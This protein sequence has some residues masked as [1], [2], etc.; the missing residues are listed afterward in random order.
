MT[1][2]T[3]TVLL[4]LTKKI[5]EGSIPSFGVGSSFGGLD[6]LDEILPETGDVIEYIDNKPFIIT[7]WGQYFLRFLKF[8]DAD[9]SQLY[10]F[11]FILFT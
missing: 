4:D 5:P 11:T 1:K 3:W 2:R 9:I 6:S 8:W 7:Q 10:K